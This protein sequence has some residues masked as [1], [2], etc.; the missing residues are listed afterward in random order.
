MKKLLI[1]ILLLASLKA[2]NQNISDLKN[3][4]SVIEDISSF[5]NRVGPMVTNTTTQIIYSKDLG[6]VEH[7]THLDFVDEKDESTI[8]M[9]LYLNDIID[10]SMTYDY[11]EI[12]D[13]EYL[14]KIRLKTKSKS[15]EIKRVSIT[16]S[17]PFPI[18]EVEITDKIEFYASGRILSKYLMEKYLENI[19]NLVGINDCPRNE[20]IKTELLKNNN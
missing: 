20:F 9:T 10:S 18:S 5:E 19:K 15:V 2:Y 11:Y 4:I 1:L 3:T 13:N 7:K 16:S 12:R 17:S 14:I 8:T 6:K